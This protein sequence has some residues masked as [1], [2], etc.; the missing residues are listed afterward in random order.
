VIYFLEHK[1]HATNK[2]FQNTNY[3]NYYSC[4]MK[5]LGVKS[6]IYR[7]K[8]YQQEITTLFWFFGKL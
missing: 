7:L 6:D 4:I 2:Y 1:E 8:I 5:Y 3:Y